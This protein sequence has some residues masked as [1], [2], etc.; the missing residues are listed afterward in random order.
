MD[1]TMAAGPR[2]ILMIAHPACLSDTTAGPFVHVSG[3]RS[4]LLELGYQVQLLRFPRLERPLF[5]S[6]HSPRRSASGCL[7]RLALPFVAAVSCLR[8]PG[9]LPYVRHYYDFSPLYVTLRLMSRPFIIEVNATLFEEPHAFARLPEAL[10]RLMRRAESFALGRASAVVVVSEVLRSR[11]IERGLEPRRVFVAHN[12]CKC[13]REQTGRFDNE[14]GR[15][16]FV[17]NFKRWHGIDALLRT[18][19][20]IEEDKRPGL[21]LVGDGELRPSMQELARELGVADSVRFLGRRSRDE[22]RRLMREALVLVLPDSNEYGSPLKLFEY[23]STGRP[24]VL[25][26]LAVIR[27][28]VKD[29]VHAVLFRPGDTSSLRDAILKVIRDPALAEKIGE[30][31]RELVC[32]QYTWLAHA[33]RVSRAIELTPGRRM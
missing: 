25:P 11:L 24:A 21:S 10:L 28:V 20:A 15:I 6:G 5:G 27:E 12:G 31:G 32:D 8:S 2:H 19:A 33:R 29:G 9:A 17:G 18:Y 13:G 1:D 14:E 26:D 23:L 30:A 22:T 7:A 3:T 16:V 4:G